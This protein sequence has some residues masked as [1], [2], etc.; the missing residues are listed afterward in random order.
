MMVCGKSSCR[1]FWKAVKPAIEDGDAHC[2]LA[3]Q[4]AQLK[5]KS[6]PSHFLGAYK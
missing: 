3:F 6:K 4:C 2:F 5:P 1:I